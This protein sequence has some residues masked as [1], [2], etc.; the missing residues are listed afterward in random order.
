MR[1]L[2]TT[3]AITVSTLCLLGS[4]RAEPPSPESLE[5][6]YK[7]TRAEA[8]VDAVYDNMKGMMAQMRQQMDPGNKLPPERRR[9]MEKAADDAMNMV[10]ADF[11]SQ[12]LQLQFVNVYG[13]TFTQEE[14]DGLI[15]F[16]ASP[17]GQSFVAKLPQVTQKSMAYTQAQMQSLM[18]RLMKLMQDAAAEASKEAPK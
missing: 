7:L 1:G 14:V 12:K 16:Y 2:S 17:V 8:M 11:T 18:P 9:I 15:A 5:R 13:E 6:L 10:R 4:A 3:L